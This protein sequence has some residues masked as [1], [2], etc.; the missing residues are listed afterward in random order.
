MPTAFRI[1]VLAGFAICGSAVAG[2]DD[3]SSGTPDP[4]C[5]ANSHIICQKA[6]DC[7]ATSECSQEYPSGSSQ[8]FN[9]E[10]QCRSAWRN[11][12]ID[13]PEGLLD[14]AVC[15]ADLAN[16]ACVDSGDHQAVQL[17]DSCYR[18]LSTQECMDYGIKIC[19]LTCACDATEACPVA[20]TPSL[21]IMYDSWGDCYS[22]MT[23]A[24]DLEYT[25]ITDYPTCMQDLDTAQCVDIIGNQ[26]IE[27]PPTCWQ[28]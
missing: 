3:G 26:G 15:E 6:C 23:G 25:G 10:S 11:Y 5:V 24:C 21:S 20:H 28:G 18:Y 2:C 17:P 14:A 13:L 12:C 16:A 8:T 4:G 7:N 19:D 1:A 22:N 9:S 27:L